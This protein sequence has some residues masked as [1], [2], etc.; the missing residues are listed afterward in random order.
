METAGGGAARF[1]Q[2]LRKGTRLA[3]GRRGLARSCTCAHARVHAV[4]AAF[5]AGGALGFH[6][7]GAWWGAAPRRGGVPW[8]GG[9]SG[10]P[11]RSLGRAV[12]CYHH[13]RASVAGGQS[14]LK[15]PSPL[16]MW[17]LGH[18]WSCPSPSCSPTPG[19][20][21]G[22]G[23][24]GSLGGSSTPRGCRAVESPC[25]WNLAAFPSAPLPK[26][27]G[28]EAGRRPASSCAGLRLRS[29]RGGSR[30]LSVHGALLTQGSGSFP[31]GE[32]QV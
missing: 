23:A 3:A 15:T 29:P 8:V 22:R 16:P 7:K 6:P 32:G 1:Q 10:T 25:S 5:G 19:G 27:F 17:L 4:F 13:L 24:V 30:L 14:P 18:I 20:P 28:G 11:S 26:H 31:A 12:P 2:R 21:P 9:R